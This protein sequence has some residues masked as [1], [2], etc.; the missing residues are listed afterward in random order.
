MKDLF[1]ALNEAYEILSDDRKREAWLERN[2]GAA[3]REEAGPLRGR[4]GA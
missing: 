2:G 1:S 4:H 3:A